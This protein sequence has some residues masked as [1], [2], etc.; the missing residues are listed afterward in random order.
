MCWKAGFV[1]GD[2]RLDEASIEVLPLAARAGARVLLQPATRIDPVAR[3]VELGDGTTV[4]YDLASLDVGSS[5]RGLDL[6]GVREHAL[7]TRPIGEFAPRLDGRLH[8]LLRDS[9]NEVRVAVVGAGAAGTEL[10]FTLRARLAAAGARPEIVLV[11]GSAGLLPGY[12]ERVRRLAAREAAAAGI[13]IA[14]TSDAAFVDESGVGFATGSLRADLVVW[15]TGAAP[16]RVIAESPL[17][18]DRD[19]F[20][21]VESTLEVRGHRGLFAAGDC[22]TIDGQ[23]WVP[24][25]GVYAVR[26][27]PVLD[28]NLRAAARGAALREFR[29]QRDFLSLMNLGDRRALATKWGF[30]VSGR[31]AW[32]LKDWIDRGF[33]RRF[34][35]AGA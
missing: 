26:A 22:A 18:H 21:L 4:G 23:E 25:A 11:C 12:P 17:P 31:G 15:A 8:E 33:V 1:A 10:C 34:R 35:T 2:Y 19:G 28:A 3:I 27:A 29:P 16:P 6:P 32:L 24:R 7:V 20:V 5:V 13:F 30:A 9:G 14:A